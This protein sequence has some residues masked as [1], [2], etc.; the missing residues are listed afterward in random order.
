VACLA[1]ND[2]FVV[3]GWSRTITNAEQEL[4]F[5]ADW[6]ASFAKFLELDIDLSAAKL[7]TRSKRFSLIVDN[8]T[9]THENVEVSAGD[10]SVTSAP[11]IVEQLK[12]LKETKTQKKE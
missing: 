4:T 8:G 11:K 2:Q 3:Q 6:D 10:F 12:E 9:I 5:I 1:V 7:G